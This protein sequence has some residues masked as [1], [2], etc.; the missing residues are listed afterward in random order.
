MVTAVQTTL[1]RLGQ[2][3]VRDSIERERDL[4]FLS[5]AYGAL[6]NSGNAANGLFMPSQACKTWRRPDADCDGR[7]LVVAVVC[8]DAHYFFPKTDKCTALAAMDR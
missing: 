1:V 8:G 3:E 5:A 7:L 6:A 4:R 2:R